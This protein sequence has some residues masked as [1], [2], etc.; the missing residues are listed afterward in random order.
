[1][2]LDLK[3]ATSNV[4]DSLEGRKMVSRAEQGNI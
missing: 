1:M 2:F 4:L 3:E